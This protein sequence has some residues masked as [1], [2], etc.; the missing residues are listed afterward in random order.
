MCYTKL[1]LNC[2]VRRHLSEAV[3]VPMNH[4]ELTPFS[5]SSSLY[6]FLSLYLPRS[7]F[8]IQFVCVTLPVSLF[9]SPLLHVLLSEHYRYHGKRRRE[10]KCICHG[11]HIYTLFLPHAVLS[12][13]VS[14]S[15][16]GS[17]LLL[18]LITAADV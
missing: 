16:S 3:K 8:G 6:I 9:V 15:R 1:I 17:T 11:F 13:T 10:M 2:D 14:V 18:S 7:A 5:L 4:T 12:L